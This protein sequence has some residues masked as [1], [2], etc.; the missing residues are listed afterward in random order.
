MGE[1]VED[2]ATKGGFAGAVE[3]YYS[4]GF[5]TGDMQ[6]DALQDV[7]PSG[8]AACD[9]LEVKHGV[10]VEKVGLGRDDADR[11]GWCR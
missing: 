11:W 4:D 1:R 9:V 10:C 3:S 8:V 7:V 6:V 2:G 5:A